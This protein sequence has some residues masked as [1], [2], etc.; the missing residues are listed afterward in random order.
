MGRT[1]AARQLIA[2]EASAES[3][4][5]ESGR[6]CGNQGAYE[7]SR[8]AVHKLQL[9]DAPHLKSP[10]HQSQLRLRDRSEHLAVRV[11]VETRNPLAGIQGWV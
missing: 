4:T 9:Q 8:D 3:G 10:S 1:N 7:P 5:R 2:L 6:P 11:L